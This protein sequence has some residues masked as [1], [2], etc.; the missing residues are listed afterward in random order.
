MTVKINN[1]HLLVLLLTG[2]V[3]K[4][5][6]S[7]LKGR[8]AA[9]AKNIFHSTL[10]STKPVEPNR[11]LLFLYARAV[12]PTDATD[13]IARRQAFE[14]LAAAASVNTFGAT[15]G[16]GRK[17]DR[18]R[19]DT[20][21]GGTDDNGA[22]QITAGPLLPTLSQQP[23][24]VHG[25]GRQ[26]L[27][28]LSLS[29]PLEP[30]APEPYQHQQQQQAAAGLCA[31][32]PARNRKQQEASTAPERPLQ[33]DEGDG[34]DDE[35][36]PPPPLLR[37]LAFP[38]ASAGTLLWGQ[39]VDGTA[40]GYGGCAVGRALEISLP[41]PPLSP[42]SNLQ[43]SVSNFSEAPS[44]PSSTAA[45]A[46]AMTT[47]SASSAHAAARYADYFEHAGRTAAGGGGGFDG[48]CYEGFCG[49]MGGQP[50][51]FFTMGLQSLMQDEELLGC[52][53]G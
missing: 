40:G 17:E 43:R 35:R 31:L 21:A 10:R 23:Q 18:C 32:F 38:A 11:R 27:P 48:V 39:E 34:D 45:A 51:G 52:L 22:M 20:A 46:V 50:T 53:L 7:K 41:L 49:G 42:S 30:A 37:S 9:E 28:L 47:R 5:I 24:R 14:R 26:P 19:S 15:D 13:R 4:Q 36:P 44:C 25:D 12:G 3:W 2:N 1:I 16:A 6:A 29:P 8:S 33:Q